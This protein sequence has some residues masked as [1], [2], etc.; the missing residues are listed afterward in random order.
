MLNVWK[1]AKTRQC[2][3]TGTLR[4]EMKE[5]QSLVV[6]VVAVDAA[7]GMCGNSEEPSC[8]QRLQTIQTGS[9]CPWG[10]SILAS[11]TLQRGARSS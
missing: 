8:P 11:L 1:T 6:L 10:Q 2:A 4:W 9:R 5:V 3:L 7:G